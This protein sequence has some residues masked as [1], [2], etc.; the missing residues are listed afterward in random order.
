MLPQQQPLQLKLQP[1]KENED[2]QHPIL[3]PPFL[4]ILTLYMY[5]IHNTYTVDVVYV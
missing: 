2:L 5:H 1:A 4:F 3:T